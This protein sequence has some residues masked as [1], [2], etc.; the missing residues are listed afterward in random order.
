MNVSN[1]SSGSGLHFWQIIY[2]AQK[3]YREFIE[4]RLHKKYKSPLEE[5]VGSTTLGSLDFVKE[6][7]K[8]SLNEKIENKLNLSKV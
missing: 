3:N 6:I 1:I 7:K 2:S 4:A 5:A 8:D